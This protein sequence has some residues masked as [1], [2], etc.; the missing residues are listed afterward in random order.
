MNGGFIVCGRL[1]VAA[2]GTVLPRPTLRGV[3]TLGEAPVRA[4]VF[5][6]AI[7]TSWDPDP[8]RPVASPTVARAQYLPGRFHAGIVFG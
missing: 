1:V 3:G 7:I 4:F 8:E 6:V 2:R 5:L